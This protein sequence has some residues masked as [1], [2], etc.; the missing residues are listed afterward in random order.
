MG[1][2]IEASSLPEDTKVYLKKDIFG[3]RTVE[4][5][6]DENGKVLWKRM[7]LGTW[8][9]RAFMGFIIL[10]VLFSYLGFKEQLNNYYSVMNNPCAYCNSCQ[11]QTKA[12]LD[13]TINGE[14]RKRF[15]DLNLTFNSPNG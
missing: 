5:I 12:V 7:I 11:E 6:K 9:E 3:W 14:A 15:S 1:E 13:A 8:R 10:L 2:I 4:P